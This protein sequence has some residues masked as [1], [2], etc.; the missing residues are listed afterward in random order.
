[1]ASQMKER[2][3]R[4]S[5]IDFHVLEMGDGPLIL[6]LHGFPDTAHSFRHQIAPLAAAGY[7]VVAPFMRGYAPTGLAA[8]GR[9][10]SAALSEDAI[11]LIVAL[12]Y[13]E[14]ILFGHDWGAVA[15][16]PAAA[17]EPA[18]VTKLITAAVPYGAS[19]IKALVENYAQQKRS[20]YMYFFQGAF[21][22]AAVSHD[23]FKF[24]EK[25]WTDWSPTWKWTRE[26]IEPLKKC[27]RTPTALSAA[28]GYYRATIGAM[29]KIPAEAISAVSAP[30]PPI[31]VPTMMLHGRDDGCIGAELLEGMEAFFPKGL[32]KEIIPSAGHFVHQEKPAEVNKLILD[33]L[34]S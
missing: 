19:F 20:W 12:G 6:C 26:D 1:M 33:F 23:D 5:N 15:A 31:N 22:E 16:Y 25:M 9:Y 11:N 14:A 29:M 10:D 21:A 13:K 7:H 4:A 18:R 24:L 3:V 17:A 32:R 34:K 30:P 27:F 2:V 8:D 28:L